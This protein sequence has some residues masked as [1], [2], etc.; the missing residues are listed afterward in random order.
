MNWIKAVR[1]RT[2]PL[3]LS[4]IITGSF[5]AKWRLDSEGNFWNWE[6]F[7]LAILVTLLYQILSNLANDYGDGIKGTDKNRA[8]EAETRAVASGK[9][10]AKQMRNAVILLAVLSL[11]ATVV[12]LYFAFYPNFIKEFWIFISLGIAC[13]LAAIGY[14]IGKKPY[15]YLGLGDA[16]VF[17]FFGLVSV[18]GSYFLFTKSLDW[19]VLLPA[20]A[21]GLMSVSVLNLNN[22]R[23]IESDRESG[24][25]TL[26]LRLGFRNAMIYEVVLLQLPLLLILIFLGLNDFFRN[27]N[28]YPFMVMILLFPMMSLRRKILKTKEPKAL[29]PFLK[30]VGIMTL[31]M[32][33]LLAFGLNYFQ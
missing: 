33:I 26:A 1:L 15:G 10:S 27:G 32:A 31:T 5:I 11:V 20:S 25:K 17:I 13:I 7:A 2:L 8:N 12:L 14:T 16:M 9:I 30:Q 23:D 18:C 22:M 28:Y 29:D 3:S 19:D 6:I 4:G 21:I 24:K